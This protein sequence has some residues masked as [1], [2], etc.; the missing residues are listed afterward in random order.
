VEPLLPQ[1]LVVLDR[2]RPPGIQ[3]PDQISD[4]RCEGGTEAREEG[5][6]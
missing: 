2:K 1:I 6:E 3:D 4:D 5:T